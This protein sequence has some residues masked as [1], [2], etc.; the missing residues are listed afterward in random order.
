MASDPIHDNIRLLCSYGQSVS[1][2]CRRA[3]FNRQQF[4]KYINGHAQPSLATLRR[5]CDFFG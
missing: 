4:N 5:I 2:I 1:D 3:G